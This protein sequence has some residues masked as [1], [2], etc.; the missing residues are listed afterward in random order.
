M[1]LESFDAL[2]KQLSSTDS[3]PK[4]VVVA[5]ATDEHTLS[6]VMALHNEGLLIPVLVGEKN[7]IVELLRK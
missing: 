6:A 3:T 7:L 2:K 5:A 4:R 1:I